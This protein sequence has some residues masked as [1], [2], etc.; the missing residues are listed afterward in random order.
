MFDSLR[1]Q[2]DQGPTYDLKATNIESPVEAMPKLVGFLGMTARQR[3]LLSV[4][5][6]VAVCILGTT[7]LLVT[8]AVRTY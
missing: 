1:D 6:L 2:E 5:F 3:L 4:L 7:C 8:G